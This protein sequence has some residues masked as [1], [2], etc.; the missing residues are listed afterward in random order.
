M[1]VSSRSILAR[2]IA[3]ATGLALVPLVATAALAGEAETSGVV[4]GGIYSDKATG[5]ITGD[6]NALNSATGRKVTFGGTFS[7]VC[8]TSGVYSSSTGWSCSGTKDHVPGQYS[9][10][11]EM[12]D[13]VWLAQATPFVNVGINASAASIAAGNWD[14]HIT[15]WATHV[16]GYLDLG[17]GRTVIIAPLQEMNSDWVPYGCD[18]TN[19]RTAFQRIVNIFRNQGMNE[20][21]VRWS[22]APNGWTT[23]GCGSIASY[24]PGHGY[25]D[26]LS[27]SAYNFGTCYPNSV[28]LTPYQ[29]LNDPLNALR[30]IAP[31]RPIV[32]AQTAAPRNSCGAPSGHSQSTWVND[33]F[34]YAASATNVAGLVYFNIVAGVDYR[35]WVNPSLVAGWQQG[36]TRSST[37]YEW[38]LTSW[39]QPGQLVVDTAPGD[40]CPPGQDCDTLALVDS[41][42]LW[43]RYAALGWSSPV[44]RFYFGNPGD[45][46]IMGDWNCDGTKTPGMY[47]QSDGF[48]YLRN[49]NTQGNADLS[50]FFGNPGDIPIAG[51]FNGNGCDTV[52][53]YRP[54]NQTFYIINQLGQN[55]GGLGA[56]TTSYMFG[57]PG[58]KPFV[59]DFNGNGQDTVGLHRES[60]GLVY[61]RNSHTQGNAD[62]QFIFG[63]PGD[64][65]FAG[66]WNG[67]GID[68]VGIY[69]P[70]NGTVYLRF[71][72]TQGNADHTLGVGA[73]IGVVRG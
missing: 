38:P 33:L 39:F 63:D 11:R 32:I 21:K 47:R 59:G 2:V 70:S 55:G 18:P 22:F 54:S 5:G 14:T 57:N 8:E 9:V 1:R 40:P 29:V 61:Y 45:Y 3:V 15:R 51:D 71:T 10:T 50:F 72:N 66:D 56:A 27:V 44:Q 49:S 13:E 7:D 58:D 12:L 52:S 69:R 35:V 17:G 67:N 4:Y 62:N 68:S 31:Q 64:K 43:H 30:A 36:M 20:T 48:V 42:A 24:Y 46:P 37:K 60:T 23:P 19:Y 6:L 34:A 28:W 16:K 25:V 41:G 26:V 73:F 53:I 65:I